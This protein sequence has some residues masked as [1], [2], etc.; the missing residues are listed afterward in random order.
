[1]SRRSGSSG[2]WKAAMKKIVALVIL[3]L[4]AVMLV[5]SACSTEPLTPVPTPTVINPGEVALTMI[6]QQMDAKA[7]EMKINVQFT[8]TAQVIAVTSTRQAYEAAIATDQQTRKDAQATDARL[9]QDAAATEQRKRDEKA[10]EQARRDAEA[11]AEQYQRNVIGTATAQQAAIWNAATMQVMPTH[12]MW[13]KQAVEQEQKIATNQVELSNLEVERQQKSNTLQALGPYMVAFIAVIVGALVMVRYS[14]TREIKNEETG[15]IEAIFLDS[16]TMIR[17]QLLPGPVLDLT[18]KTPSVPLLTDSANQ[19]EIVRRSQMAEALRAMPTQAPTQMA[20]GMMSSVFG[21]ETPSRFQ[22][23]DEHEAPPA[24][25]LDAEA[26]KSLEHD[27][28][29]KSDEQL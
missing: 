7:T 29:E 21:G 24:Q 23:L 20:A 12:N 28:K 25:L 6:M 26:L 5:L 9:R 17:P 1:M 27:W 3:G 8:A 13:T 16:R 22:I 4:F 15:A 10:T 18:G 14:R 2:N 19:A 11:T